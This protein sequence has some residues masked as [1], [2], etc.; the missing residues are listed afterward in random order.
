MAEKSTRSIEELAEKR[1]RSIEELAE[2]RTR[3]IEEIERDIA[4]TRVDLMA[5]VEELQKAVRSRLDWRRPIRL[6]P[7][8]IIGA[9]FALAFLIGWRMAGE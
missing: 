9:A 1:T 3:S 8:P 2:K 7:F 6:H 4:R 5:D